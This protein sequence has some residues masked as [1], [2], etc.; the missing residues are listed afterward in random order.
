MSGNIPDVDWST[1]PPIKKKKRKR[2]ILVNNVN[3]G[4][5]DEFHRYDPEDFH[6]EERETATPIVPDSGRPDDNALAVR[7]RA[8]GGGSTRGDGK[9]A[10]PSVIPDTIQLL[11][12]IRGWM[13]GKRQMLYFK[14]RA[15]EL[16]RFIDKINNI[17]K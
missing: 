12:E 3:P 2:K 10:V 16:D 15:K 5:S 6:V 4:V 14:N 1:S 9:A 13:E 11:I 17:I 8:R 7:D